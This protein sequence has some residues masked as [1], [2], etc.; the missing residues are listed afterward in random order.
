[1][2]VTT[3]AGHHPGR[4][5]RSRDCVWKP[6]RYVLHDLLKSHHN[7]VITTLIKYRGKLAACLSIVLELSAVFGIMQPDR[8]C[9]CLAPPD[10]TL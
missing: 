3:R 1:M 7:V 10:Q 6:D 4:R 2:A 8:G 5:W 9:H